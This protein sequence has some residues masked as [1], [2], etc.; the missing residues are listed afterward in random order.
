MTKDRPT[1]LPIV[2]NPQNIPHCGK[3]FV[4]TRY[5]LLMKKKVER[6][7]LKLLIDFSAY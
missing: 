6:V 3:Q 4:Y 5:T 7:D 1:N 2:G